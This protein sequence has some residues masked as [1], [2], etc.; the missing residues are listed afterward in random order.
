MLKTN[1]YLDKRTG[2]TLPVVAMAQ[3][4]TTMGYA[5]FLIGV[6]RD[7]IKNGKIIDKVK[8]SI[9]FDRNRNPFEQAYEVAK[10][11]KLESRWNEELG[12]MEGVLV[13]QPFHG[14]VDE[15]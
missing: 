11:Q 14:W 9:D 3:V 12:K 13:N 4:D 2:L 6:S 8:M 7:A 10:G 15:L 1:N 5:T